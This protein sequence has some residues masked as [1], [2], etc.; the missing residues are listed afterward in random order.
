MQKYIIIMNWMSSLPIVHFF[1][2]FYH[3]FHKLYG[4]VFVLTKINIFIRFN[5]CILSIN[6]FFCG[7]LFEIRIMLENAYTFLPLS[8]GFN[9]DSLIFISSYFFKYVFAYSLFFSYL[10]FSSSMSYSFLSGSR[11]GSSPITSLFSTLRV[12][13]NPSQ[14]MCT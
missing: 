3:L 5:I 9:L 11:S 1:H 10:V 2:F 4:F 13:Y 7:V 12:H 14:P 8:I 6:P